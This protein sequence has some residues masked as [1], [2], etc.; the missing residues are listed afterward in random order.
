MFVAEKSGSGEL[1]DMSHNVLAGQSQNF[2]QLAD[3]EVR[4]R[5][6]SQ[7]PKPIKMSSRP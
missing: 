1:S 5:A 3:G 7:N 6:K 4:M 2:C